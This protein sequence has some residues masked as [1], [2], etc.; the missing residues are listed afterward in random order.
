MTNFNNLANLYDNGKDLE[1]WDK[2]N[3]PDEKLIYSK[4]MRSQITRISGL[5]NILPNHSDIFN[6][7]KIVGSHSSKSVGLPVSCF[8]FN[9][10]GQVVAYAFIRDNFYDIK[11]VVISDSPIHIPYHVMYNEWNQEKYDHEAKRYLGYPGVEVIGQEKQKEKKEL[12][13]SGDDWYHTNW[14]GGRI[15]RKN[16][17]IYQTSS[18]HEVYCE[19]INELGL[20]KEVFKTYEEGMYEF[21][22]AIGSYPTAA[23]IL[24]YVVKSLEKERYKRNQERYDT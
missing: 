18:C 19:G 20:H 9:P 7:P 8:K 17:R 13:E 12:L 3:T 16:D 11:V 6:P 23:K 22:C 14:A 24:E 1:T 15:L 10:Y 5:A 4:G 21:V 2:E